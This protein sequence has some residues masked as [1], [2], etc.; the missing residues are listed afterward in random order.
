M[1]ELAALRRIRPHAGPPSEAAYRLAA[2]RLHDAILSERRSRLARHRMVLPG[3]GISL[4]AAVV[5]V[6]VII[7]TGRSAAPAS[8]AAVL[9]RAAAAARS[10]PSLVSLPP[11]HFLYIR[12]VDA[13]LATDDDA[14]SFSVLLPHV[15]ELWLG[16]HSGRLR[17]RSGKPVFLSERDRRRWIAAGR[18]RLPGEGTSDMRI[19]SQRL[20]LPSRPDAAYAV[21]ARQARTKDSSFAWAMFQLIGDD[22]RETLSAPAQR[23][24]LLAAAARVPG[25][26]LV[27]NVTDRAGR[28]GVAI[29]V[30]SDDDHERLELIV[31]PG[32]GE[33]LGEEE[34]VLAGNSFGYRPGTVIGHV[35]YLETA[36]V[37]SDHARPRRS[38]S[39]PASAAA[40]EAS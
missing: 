1:S 8:A 22:L 35:T 14:P 13:Y 21:L 27:G 26:V 30:H 4:A 38:G 28:R 18:P 24:A 7:A 15:S 3:L 33:L 11:G 10:R 23:A 6:V 39:Q 9:E 16:S 5:A 12:S 17:E 19:R 34:I 36:V 29:A 25:I 37:A 2:D 32:T 20:M 40:T 31:D